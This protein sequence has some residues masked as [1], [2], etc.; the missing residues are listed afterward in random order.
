M[1]T[2]TSAKRADKLWN[3]IVS[4]RFY[5][6]G[7]W[8]STCHA[9]HENKRK[10]G[11]NISVLAIFVFI[12]ILTNTASTRGA[13]VTENSN[14]RS[15]ANFENLIQN[16]VFARHRRQSPEY[17][18]TNYNVF[19][20]ETT[21]DEI[22]DSFHYSS[23]NYDYDMVGPDNDFLEKWVRELYK[24]PGNEYDCIISHISYDSNI[25]TENHYR[26]KQ[27]K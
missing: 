26:Q 2:R 17:D 5:D 8:P 16:E 19:P 9:Q 23:E 6:S 25:Q 1:L 22:G 12:I 11:V 15:S 14:A 10:A 3:M 24:G 18:D 27:L 7:C 21:T 20:P 4:E 13:R